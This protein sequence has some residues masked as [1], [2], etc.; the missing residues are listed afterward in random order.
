METVFERFGLISSLPA[1]FRAAS[2]VTALWD[3]YINYYTERL[4]R[5]DESAIKVRRWGSERT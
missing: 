2:R 3:Y 1:R 4:P 5:G